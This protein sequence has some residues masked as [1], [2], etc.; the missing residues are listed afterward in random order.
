MAPNI[1][2]LKIENDNK[3]EEI[4][5]IAKGLGH[6]AERETDK[7]LITDDNEEVSREEL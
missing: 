1:E 6:S 7:G 2:A 3:I 5:K 4:Q